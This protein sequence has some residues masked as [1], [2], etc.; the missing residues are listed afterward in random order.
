[1]TNYFTNLLNRFQL[2]HEITEISVILQP[3][4]FER[5]KTRDRVKVG[6]SVNWA[7]SANSVNLANYINWANSV[8]SAS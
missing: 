8:N 3:Q 5:V 1:M 2:F 6:E 7:N 4:I